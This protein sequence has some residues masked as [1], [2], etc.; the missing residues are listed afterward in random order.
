MHV[1]SC[2]YTVPTAHPR[3]STNEILFCAYGVDA[4]NVEGGEGAASSASSP[5]MLVERSLSTVSDLS[6]C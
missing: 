6:G 5:A 3:A 1:S 2:L 4:R